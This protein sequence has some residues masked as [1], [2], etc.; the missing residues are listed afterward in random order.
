MTNIDNRNEDIF[1]RGCLVKLE[2]SCWTGRAKIPSRVLL[3]GS[4]HAGVDPKFVG[5][6]KKLVD[7]ET[8]REV[9]RVRG[10]A[11]AWLGSRSLPF[12]VDGVVFVP[13]AEINRIDAKL[14]EFAERFSKA[15]DDFAADF[16]A[17]RGA[18]RENLGT[19]Y[20]ER[21]YPADVRSRFAFHWRFLSLAPAGE[22]QLLDPEL[23][24]RERNKFQVL[25]Q[26]ASQQ[27]VAELRSRFAQTVDHMVERLTGEREGGKSLVFRES[28]VGNVR[29]FVESFASLN[30]SNDQ[31]LAALVERARSTL[32]G[33]EVSKLRSDNQLRSRVAAQMATVQEKL[34]GMLVDRPTRKLRFG[35]VGE[36]PAPAVELEQVHV[37][38]LAQQAAAGEV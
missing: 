19:L 23:V 31:E 10:E 29:E 37:P 13:A 22:S 3:D 7:G 2:T 17:L 36:A 8:L 5:A 25:I 33:V 28:L 34:D 15:A 32:D 18:A 24:A 6:H 16:D 20:S 26:E 35:A 4:T 21:D 9:E 27:A 38:E 30:I 1:S 11:R 12:P 14:T